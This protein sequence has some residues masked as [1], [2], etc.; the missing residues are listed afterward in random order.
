MKRRLGWIVIVGILLFTIALLAIGLI[1]TRT[2]LAETRADLSVT[3]FFLDITREQEPPE[4]FLRISV[5]LY[6][7][8]KKK[9]AYQFLEYAIFKMDNQ[10]QEDLSLLPTQMLR[11]PV[12]AKKLGLKVTKKGSQGNIRRF[13]GG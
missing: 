9:A 11:D 4:A 8:G 10:R 2:K 13:G 6:T 1:S 12:I 5:V 7:E 3:K